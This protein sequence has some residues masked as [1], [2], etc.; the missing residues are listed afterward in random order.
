M[1]LKK[2]VSRLVNRDDCPK[3]LQELYAGKE[4]ELAKLGFRYSHCHVTED[5]VRKR[6]SE[7]H[8]FIYYNEEKE[9]YASMTVSPQ[10]DFIIP[11]W[12]SFETY[13]TNGEKCSTMDGIRHEIIDSIP[14]TVLQDN[15][16][17]SIKEQWDLHLSYLEKNPQL[18]IKTFP[19]TE[20]GF[21]EKL[22]TDTR[23]YQKY[24]EH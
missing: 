20:S 19:P 9:T 18:E 6:H 23:S 15:Y 11:V 24:L 7:K 16:S 1:I 3:Y 8:Y 17:G 2:P 4:E 10:A 14:G 12:I 21:Q 22:D 5:M 13:F